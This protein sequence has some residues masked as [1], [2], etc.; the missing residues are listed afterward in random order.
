MSGTAATSSTNASGS[1]TRDA[2]YIADALE[3]AFD[4]IPDF[5]IG[6]KRVTYGPTDLP[7]DPVER[8]LV[9]HEVD[10]LCSQQVINPTSVLPW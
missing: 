1:P 6:E 3:R 4:D 9:E 7:T 2:L 10:C 5:D 8:G